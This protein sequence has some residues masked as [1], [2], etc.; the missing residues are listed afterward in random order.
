[1]C[2]VQKRT[3]PRKPRSRFRVINDRS[4]ICGFSMSSKTANEPCNQTPQ[5]LLVTPGSKKILLR[6][7]FIPVALQLNV[8]SR[9]SWRSPPIGAG[10]IEVLSSWVGDCWGS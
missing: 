5:M 10:G 7:A 9:S 4:R 3:H 1:M 8:K 6:S 2:S